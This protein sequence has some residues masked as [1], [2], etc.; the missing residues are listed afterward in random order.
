MRVEFVLTFRSGCTGTATIQKLS[1]AS[2]LASCATYSGDIVVATD[3]VTADQNHNGHLS[4]DGIKIINGSLI[5]RDVPL[6][7]SLSGP[8][9]QRVNYDMSFQNLTNL[10]TI[11][12]PQL[13]GVGKTFRLQDLP[14][15]DTLNFPAQVEFGAVVIQNTAIRS[16]DNS[17]FS[18]SGLG[19]CIWRQY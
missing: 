15:L 4:L 3:L 16:L 2:A 17:S 8:S 13:G 12:F 10:S 5:A 11:P 18:T 1:D 19:R 6:L 7:L 14:Q 9:L